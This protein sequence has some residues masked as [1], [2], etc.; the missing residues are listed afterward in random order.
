MLLLFTMLIALFETTELDFD[1]TVAEIQR[2]A[3][4]QDLEALSSARDTLRAA[5]DEA[6]AEA[7]V[8]VDAADKLRL[9]YAHAFASW[10][11]AGGEPQGS[12]TYKAYLK[13]A[14]KPLEEVLAQ[15]PEHAEAQALYASVNGWLITGMW[16]GMRRGPRADKA[17]KKARELAPENPRVAMHQGVSRL[18][19]PGMFG[20]GLD[21]AEAELT[22]A[23]DLFEK[24][25]AEKA[26]PNGGHAEILAWMG[27]VMFRKGEMNKAREY[28]ERALELEPNYHW[29]LQVLLPQLEAAATK[30][31]GR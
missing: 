20:G 10:K 27:Q 4:E 17:L 1:A 25:P 2:A 30:N 13:D 8:E 28:Y 15:N 11:L 12:K 18:F 14:E 26:W 31:R 19:R 6:E 29:V 24:E 22:E 16:S 7:E 3:I 5:I 23:L 21:K 9:R